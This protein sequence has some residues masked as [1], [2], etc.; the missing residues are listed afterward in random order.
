MYND[1]PMKPLAPNSGEQARWDHTG[2]RR[3]MILGAWEED[4]EEE[5]EK[6]FKDLNEDLEA[7]KKDVSGDEI[8]NYVTAFILGRMFGKFEKNTGAK[9]TIEQ[10][11]IDD[12]EHE[13]IESVVL[14]RH[15]VG[16]TVER[17]K[18]KIVLALQEFERITQF[19]CNYSGCRPRPNSRAADDQR[20]ANAGV[21]NSP[22]HVRCIA[23]AAFVEGP[24]AVTQ[25][26][27]FPTGFGVANQGQ[28][29]H[30][31]SLHQA[32][33]KSGFVGHHALVPRWIKNEIDDDIGNCRDDGDLLLRILYKDVTHT[34]ARRS[35][36]HVNTHRAL[37]IAEWG[38]VAP[39]NQPELDDIDGNFRVVTGLEL[40]PDD[41]FDIGVRGT[42]GNFGRRYRLL[43]QCI[44]IDA[45]HAEQIAL[46]VDGKA[47]AEG[48]CNKAICALTQRQFLSGRDDNCP[49]IA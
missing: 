43:A 1:K 49:D 24:F 48:L 6:I 36:C 27:V 29:L 38:H 13:I 21:G 7:V 8:S 28:G 5:L 19:R 31:G 30:T 33:L 35:Q 18:V 14:C 3:R 11:D 15:H 4:L 22:G 12:E 16:P 44:G 47:A 2:L 39:I 37:A 25:R 17:G 34:A 42:F 20:G 10:V 23:T 41:G 40:F 46:D 9:V 26:P 45:G 32:G